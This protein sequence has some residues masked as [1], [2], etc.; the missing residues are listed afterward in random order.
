[1]PEWA[2]RIRW[3]K[4]LASKAPKVENKVAFVFPAWLKKHDEQEEVRIVPPSL[5]K[6]LGDEK[7]NQLKYI[8]AQGLL[9]AVG[10][11]YTER[12]R[13]ITRNS[14]NEIIR[15]EETVKT[16]HQP[17]N[18]ALLT[19]FITNISKQLGDNAWQQ[20]IMPFQDNRQVTIQIDGRI[21][22]ERIAQ[23]AR[24]FL[25]GHSEGHNS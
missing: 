7:E 12:T 11:D 16:G 2:F 6:M 24:G 4:K 14:N 10:Y 25:E 15:D 20:K 17:A 5:M 3:E 13:K 21:E 9:D 22:S 19:F 1:M 23:F 8:V 18:Q